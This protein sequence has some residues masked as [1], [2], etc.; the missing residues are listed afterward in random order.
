VEK[1]PIVI[2]GYNRADNLQRL[3]NNLRTSRPQT[4]IFSV[5][6]PKPHIPGDEENVA[7]VRKLAETIDWTDDVETRFRE[8][9]LGLKAA[10]SDSVSHAVSKFGRAIILED[11]TAPNYNFAPYMTAMLDRYSSEREIEHI[12]GYNLVPSDKLAHPNHGSRLTRYPESFAWGTWERAWSGYD[13]SLE[14][15]L[16]ASLKDIARITGSLAGAMRWKQNFHDAASERISSWAYRWISSMWSR[17]AFVL[18]PN[19][20]LVTYTGFDSGTHTV[21][22]APWSEL[23]LFDGDPSELAEGEPAYDARA[24]EWVGRTIFAET[25]FGVTRGV[26]I[27]AALAARKRYRAYKR[28]RASQG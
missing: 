13:D 24:D 8:S 10:V 7:A 6:G 16:N 14:W 23:E 17:D 20:N 22:K 27:S 19:A 9:N 4:I 1:T 3:L 5:D 12:S 18:S 26:A 21:M 28:T 15:A 2:L 11:D 25:A